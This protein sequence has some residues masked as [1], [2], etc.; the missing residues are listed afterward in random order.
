MDGRLHPA[1]TSTTSDSDDCSIKICQVGGRIGTE[2]CKFDIFGGF[3]DFSV[4]FD[5]RNSWLTRGCGRNIIEI[6][7]GPPILA[8]TLVYSY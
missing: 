5:M 6:T 2:I 3:C 7:K 4:V 1:D 8:V